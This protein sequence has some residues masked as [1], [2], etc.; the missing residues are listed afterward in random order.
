MSF[1]GLALACG[2][3]AARPK[4]ERRG[5]PQGL[6]SGGDG[7]PDLMPRSRPIGP[8]GFEVR[9]LS[10]ARATLIDGQAQHWEHAWRAS[11]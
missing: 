11:S 9:P 3:A 2:N 10:G 6:R 1:H 4:F 7:A 5:M 8:A